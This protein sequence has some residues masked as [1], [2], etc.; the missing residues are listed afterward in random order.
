MKKWQSILINLGVLFGGYY[1][2]KIKDAA[3]KDT[4]LAGAAVVSAATTNKTSN[5]NPDGT[6]AQ[7]PFVKQP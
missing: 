4:I 6:P 2:S 5:S 3:L 1:A 7:Q